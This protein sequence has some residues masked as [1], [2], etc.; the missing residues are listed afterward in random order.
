MTMRNMLLL[1]IMSADV[2]THEQDAKKLINE[3]MKAFGG[4]SREYQLLFITG[5]F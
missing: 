5:L 4:E 2:L 1:W 3:S